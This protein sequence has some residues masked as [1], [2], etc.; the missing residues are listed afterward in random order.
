[1]ALLLDFLGYLVDPEKQERRWERKHME[2]EQLL[3][4]S[5]RKSDERW[6][7]ILRHYAQLQ[8]IDFITQKKK[9]L[10]THETENIIRLMKLDTEDRR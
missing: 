5:R 9:E 1:M 6:D 10:I 7:F 3:E 8:M 4:W 2:I